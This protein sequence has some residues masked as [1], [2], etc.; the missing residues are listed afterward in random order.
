MPWL[1]HCIGKLRNQVTRSS[2]SNSRVAGAMSLKSTRLRPCFAGAFNS[3]SA[4]SSG[5]HSISSVLS[6]VRNQ[7][8]AMNDQIRSNGFEISDDGFQRRQIPVNV[9]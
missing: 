1:A 8:T 6:A 5:R 9:G 3:S 4:R 2:P 7:V